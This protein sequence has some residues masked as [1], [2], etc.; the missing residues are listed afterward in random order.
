MRNMKYS[1]LAASVLSLTTMSAN[2]SSF[3]TRS[4]AMGGIGVSS[5]DYLTAP[6]HNPALAARYHKSDDFGVL[7]PSVGVAVQGSE[8]TIDNF[9]DTLDIVQDYNDLVAS[10]IQ[11]LDDAQQV[12]DQLSSLQGDSATLR[13]GTGMAVALPNQLISVNMYAK[14][15]LDAVISTKVDQAD[16][17]INNYI[18]GSYAP[19][20]SGNL[21][22]VAVTE[23]GVALARSQELGDG[24]IYY[25]V[26]PKVQNIQAINYTANMDNFETD[27]IFEDQYVNS[28]TFFNM[29]L[30]VA[31]S[32]N[33]GVSLGFVAKN[34]FN[35]ELDTVNFQSVQGT[36]HLNT[37]YTASAS[38][39]NSWLTLG[40]DAD[41]N[42]A[43][44]FEQST[45]LAF[46]KSSD[47]TQM[48]GVGA[49]FNAFNW[50]QLRV[51][52]KMDL[53][54]NMEDEITAG[55][56][57]VPFEVWHIDLSASYAGDHQFGASVQ[58]YFT[59]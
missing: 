49:E 21:I 59:F 47:D 24:N 30:G 20:S 15:Y 34:L 50:A 58:T 10:G 32:F 8:D 26:S 42:A 22:G 52:Y 17:D 5:A 44:R 38:Y 36:Y 55:I 1:L 19:Q 41:L 43:K 25:G 53:Q 6:F 13:A 2:A 28:D 29:D 23:V 18:T 3:D 54:D 57:L 48:V 31:Y 12:I 9:S 11:S 40:V 46:D 7:L 35:Q 51:G 14:S 45:G 4:F 37:I 56:G 16:L 33:N 27:D 39:A